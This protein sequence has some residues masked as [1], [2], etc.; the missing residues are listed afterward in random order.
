MT[1]PPCPRPYAPVRPGRGRV[2]A[3]LTLTLAAL[4][5]LAAAIVRLGS[6]P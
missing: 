1:W 2:I 3:L 6:C 5:F 4:G